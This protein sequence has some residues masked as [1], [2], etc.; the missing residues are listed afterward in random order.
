VPGKSET[1]ASYSQVGLLY[2]SGYIEARQPQQS[3]SRQPPMPIDYISSS[4]P[5][6]MSEDDPVDMS[7]DEMYYR[8]VNAVHR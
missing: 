2:N 3:T 4:R 5:K 1:N 7:D 8:Q 6:E